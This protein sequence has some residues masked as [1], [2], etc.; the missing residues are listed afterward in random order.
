[1][2]AITSILAACGSDAGSPGQEQ[3]GDAGNIDSG[4]LDGNVVDGGGSP[5]D[6]SSKEGGGGCASG[7]GMAVD[8]VIVIVQENHTFDSYFG[9][10]C[11]AQ[12]G[13]NPTCTAGPSCCEAAPAMD[14]SGA[15]PVVLDDT[16][17]RGYDPNHNQACMVAEIDNG[18][19]DAFVTAAMCGS[20]KN[21]A[22]APAAVIKPYTDLAEQNAIADRYFQ[23]IAGASSSN[24]M[25]L[26]VANEVFI[27]N[28]FEAQAT[29]SQ[30]ATNTNVIS[31]GGKTTIAD[32]LKNAGKTVTWYSEG[33]AAMQAA[34]NSCPPA[35]MGCALGLSTY[36][37]VFDPGDVPFLYYSQFEGTS[38]L[39][40]DF[41]S[42]SGDLSNG[43]LP[44]V[45]FVKALG[46]RSE[47]PGN[48]DKISDG[49]SFVTG[50]VQ[51]VENSCYKDSTLILLTW[52]EGGGFFDHVPPPPTSTVDNQPYGTRVPL[53]AI[54][55][56][57]AKGVVSHVTMEH[58]SIVKFLEYNYLGGHTGQLGARDAVVNNIGSLLDPGATK[59]TVPAQ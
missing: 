46:F 51:A 34:G 53:L 59:A 55:H 47:H 54:G 10:W 17:N 13:S 36:P 5:F 56:Y 25:Y 48:G 43:A 19:M 37:C 4:A 2:L 33:Y 16:E 11:T 18:K 6:G 22:I 41:A 45:S 50:V 28:T 23:P 7:T 39:V 42:L 32:L 52:D 14:P 26:A 9:A 38:D 24:D 40:R 31:Y 44:D 27:D 29:G 3:N 15:S 21:W 49:T 12:A 20:A 35:A 57:A 30:C 58:S 8:H 1:M